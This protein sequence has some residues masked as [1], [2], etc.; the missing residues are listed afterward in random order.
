MTDHEIHGSGRALVI[1]EAG[2]P[3]RLAEARTRAKHTLSS[4]ARALEVSTTYM[5]RM[6]AGEKPISAVRLAQMAR[7]YKTTMDW[8]WNGAGSDYACV[9]SV[10]LVSTDPRGIWD[11]SCNPTRRD[12]PWRMR[13]TWKTPAG[14]V[15]SRTVYGNDFTTCVRDVMQAC[16]EAE[17]A[18]DD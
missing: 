2:L 9:N 18:N 17:A 15:R 10:T 4:A 5:R 11:M 14:K 8:L 16:A 7:L 3:A 13:R 12:L 1:R 6:E